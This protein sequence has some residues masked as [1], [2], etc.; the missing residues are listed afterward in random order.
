MYYRN[1]ILCYIIMGIGF[2]NLA[3][4]L[5]KC[6]QSKRSLKVI[7]LYTNVIKTISKKGN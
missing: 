4:N 1:V 7:E 3:V 6:E 5:K 2:G